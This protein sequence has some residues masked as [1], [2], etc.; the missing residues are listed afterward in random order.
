MSDEE[1]PPA[2]CFKYSSK[3]GAAEMDLRG[4]ASAKGA[5]SRVS[6]MPPAPTCWLMAVDE[7]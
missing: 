3:D 1:A 2:R 5:G 4:S 7:R 6:A